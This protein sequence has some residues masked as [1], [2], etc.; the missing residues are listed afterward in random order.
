[1]QLSSMV[2]KLYHGEALQHSLSNQLTVAES[3]CRNSGIYHGPFPSKYIVV[4]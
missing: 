3:E 1:M 4:K 2:E